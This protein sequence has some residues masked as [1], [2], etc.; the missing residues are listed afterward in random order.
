MRNAGV[1]FGLIARRKTHFDTVSHLPA[2]LVFKGRLHGEIVLS[3]CGY[4]RLVR[5]GVASHGLDASLLLVF[6][7]A[8]GCLGLW[9]TFGQ[10]VEYAHRTTFGDPFL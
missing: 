3:R 5:G 8:N 7:Q 4:Q 1:I 10:R 6:D 9:K 2:T